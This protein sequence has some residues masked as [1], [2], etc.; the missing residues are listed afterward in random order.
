MT[1]SGSSQKERSVRRKGLHI[2]LL[3]DFARV[4]LWTPVSIDSQKRWSKTHIIVRGRIILLRPRFQRSWSSLCDESRYSVT[5][6]SLSIFRNRS[7]NIADWTD[8]SD[9]CC[10]LT[11]RNRGDLRVTIL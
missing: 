8:S 5:Q 11:H 4:I 7:Y 6:D 9:K 2:S 1:N 3:R 10:G